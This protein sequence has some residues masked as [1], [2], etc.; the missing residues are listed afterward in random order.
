[1]ST[2]VQTARLK[3]SRGLLELDVPLRMKGGPTVMLH[4]KACLLTPDLHLSSPTLDFGPVQTGKC[5][6]LSHEH[7]RQSLFAHVSAYTLVCC[8]TGGLTV[9]CILAFCPWWPPGLHL[10]VYARCRL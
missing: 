9:M 5:K 2:C 3:L 10:S 8:I 4:I 6:V 1:M 7:R